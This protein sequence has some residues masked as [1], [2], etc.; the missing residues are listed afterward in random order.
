M[1]ILVIPCTSETPFGTCLSKRISANELLR[2][3]D[4][5]IFQTVFCEGKQSAVIPE[6]GV[7]MGQPRGSDTQGIDYST[8]ETRP[9][10]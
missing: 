1:G 6:N 5:K 4:D 10:G 7:P 3:V 9:K 2:Q 8:L